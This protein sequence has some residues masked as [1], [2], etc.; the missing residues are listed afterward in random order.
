MSSVT[1]GMPRFKNTRNTSHRYRIRPG[2]SS[3]SSVLKDIKQTKIVQR[4]CVTGSVM[5]HL[6]QHLMSLDGSEF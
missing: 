2:W 1:L 5:Q 6:S 4:K 3:N